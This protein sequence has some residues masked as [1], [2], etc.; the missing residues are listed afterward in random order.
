V[1][2]PANTTASWNPLALVSFLLALVFPAGVILAQLA[3]GVFQPVNA[4]TP[5]A[6]HAGV[7]LL[8]AGVLAVPLALFAGHGALDRA[9]RR[10]YRWP[11]RALALA[12]LVLGY[13]A[14]LG[15]AIGL[16]LYYWG[17]THQRWHLVG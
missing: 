10:A 1:A 14:L 8:M 9:S 5:P 13:G 7:A 3:G 17:V 4:S 12:G 2:T 15:Y 11:L 16:V 6:Y